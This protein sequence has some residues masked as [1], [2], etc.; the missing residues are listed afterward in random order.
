MPE[1]NLEKS[2]KLFLELDLA[3]KASSNTFEWFT[4]YIRLPLV[5]TTTKKFLSNSHLTLNMREF[6]SL[7]ILA[8]YPE[9]S[10][11]GER[12]ELEER[13]YQKSK[14]IIKNVYAKSFTSEVFCHLCEEFYTLF[15]LWKRQDKEDLIKIL[16]TTRKQV[17]GL[18]GQVPEQEHLDKTLNTIESLASD[19]K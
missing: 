9:C 16:A 3:E 4:R 10:L 13:V 5:V 17:S 7:F 1:D 14:E 8:Y 11:S 19:F 18:S 2:R 6:I 15:N 12:N